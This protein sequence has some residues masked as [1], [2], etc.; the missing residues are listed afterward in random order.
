MEQ[1]DKPCKKFNATYEYYNSSE[2]YVYDADIESFII[3][4]YRGLRYKLAIRVESNEYY[5]FQK[6]FST[7]WSI[8][9]IARTIAHEFTVHRTSSMMLELLGIGVASIQVNLIKYKTEYRKRTPDRKSFVLAEIVE[10]YIQRQK[11]TPS[12]EKIKSILIDAYQFYK[13]DDTARRHY[14]RIIGT[15][16][17]KEIESN[18]I[19]SMIEIKRPRGRPRKY[20]PQKTHNT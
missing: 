12:F 2:H 1:E 4:E 19:K 18:E 11:D 16:S 9:R 6:C 15:V 10:S 14:N 13:T 7:P 5:G 3:I 17:Y 20:P 8:E